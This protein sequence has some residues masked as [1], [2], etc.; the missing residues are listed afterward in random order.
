M[1][2]AAAAAPPA[3]RQSR[4]KLA[5]VTKGPLQRPH[6]IA[7]HGVEGIGKTTFGACAPNPIFLASEDGASQLDVQRFPQPE[8]WRDA[9]D[10]VAELTNEKHDRQTLVVDTL[11]WLEPMVWAHI[12]S[13]TDKKSVEDFGYGK[14][15]VKAVDEWRIFLAALERMRA[16]KPMHVILLA[17]T[18]VKAFNNPEGENYDRYQMK[19]HAS[20][21]ALIREWADAVFFANHETVTRKEKDERKAKGLST[22]ARLLY[23]E[24]SAA[25]DAK[26]HYNLPPTLPLSWDDFISA[27]E[28]REVADP[29][30]MIAAITQNADLLPDSVKA[31]TLASLERAGTDP[32]KLARL[33]S[34]VL[35]KV[36]QR[37]RAAA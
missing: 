13:G 12:C 9:L 25:W 16:A 23:T 33:H 2:T 17:H 6:R 4:M 10:A 15:Y 26:N 19:L 18:S 14:G 24:R 27:V 32:I 31:D 22:G 29:A 28:K 20:A 3:P 35:S 8:T 1:T 37:N 34:W 5:N 11:D 7:I 21:A 30:E 36:A